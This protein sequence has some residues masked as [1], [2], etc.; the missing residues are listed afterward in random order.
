MYFRVEDYHFGQKGGHFMGSPSFALFARL[1]L[2]QDQYAMNIECKVEANAFQKKN[3]HINEN[4]KYQI[5]W[6][7]ISYW[8]L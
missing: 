4:C 8:L 6:T 1:Y 7:N 5:H 3:I 2:Q